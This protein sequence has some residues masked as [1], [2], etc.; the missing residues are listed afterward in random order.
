MKKI[1]LLGNPNCGKTTLFNTLTKSHKITGNRI[2]VTVEATSGIYKGKGIKYEIIDLPGIFSLSP[3]TEEERVVS[4]YLQKEKYDAILLCI[5][6]QNPKRALKLIKDIQAAGKPVI[7]AFNFEDILLKNNIT[8]NLKEA[9]KLLGFP[10]ISIS[11]K[12]EKS[13]DGLMKLVGTEIDKN[14]KQGG[15]PSDLSP[16]EFEKRVLGNKND[17]TRKNYTPDKIF[18]EKYWAHIFLFAFTAIIFFLAFSGL[19]SR[20]SEAVENLF[21]LITQGEFR[22]IL[23]ESTNPLFASLIC[24]GV[25][26]G[27]G[28][29]LC[30]LP[31]IGVL[32]ALLAIFEDSGYL[33]RTAYILDAPLKKI[34]LQ[35]KCFFCL[36]SGFGCTVGG[37]VS[38]R[39]LENRR[40]R[41][42]TALLLPF[43]PCSA[44]LPLLLMAEKLFFGSS[45]FVVAMYAL[46]IFSGLFLN[47][48]Y[49]KCKKRSKKMFIL[50]LPPYRFPSYKSVKYSV[51]TRLKDFIFKAGTVLVMGN[52]L[53]WLLS[54]F[55]PK[56]IFTEN[57]DNSMLYFLGE[58]LLPI[59][60]PM[61]LSS[62][63][64]TVS[65][66]SGFIAREGIVSTLKI[67]YNDENSI[68]E[69]FSKA[70]ATAFC[71]LSLTAPPCIGALSAIFR[72]IKSKKLFF[73]W[74]LCS[75]GF[76]YLFSILVY[77]V[78]RLIF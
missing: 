71:I 17:F 10:C 66:F 14:R 54:S 8:L 61:G 78:G 39:I 31:Q 49:E 26:A 46:S 62:W 25:I 67:L 77:N 48:I 44:K 15:L 9:Q 20:L 42:K 33:A 37:V 68:T 23:K 35:G 5:D 45:F 40:D 30:F 43:I 2:G 76:A 1:I 73:I 75:F 50:E 64:Q 19:T 22:V 32:T 34:G 57:G 47:K 29:V 55:T 70:S 36:M 53:I 21:S 69:A 16:E 72:E 63:K 38:A 11:A 52:V 58:A 7:G 59:F 13:V 56:M 6:S 74:L 12:K 41:I 65:L 28:S 51:I 27:M 18:L 60:K 3:F 24:D 4:Q